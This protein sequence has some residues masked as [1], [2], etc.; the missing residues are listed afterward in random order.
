MLRAEIK[1]E[2]LLDLELQFEW[3]ADKA[4]EDIGERYLQAFRETKDSLCRQSDLGRIRKFR[5]LRLVGIRSFRIERPF[6]KHLI[7]YRVENDKLIIFRVLHGV[8]DLP[9]R[10]IDPPGAV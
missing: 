7:F 5:D 4:G 10:L 2:A 8:R 6:E 3:F 9:R 1:A